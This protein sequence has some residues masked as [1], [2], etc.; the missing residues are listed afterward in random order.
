MEK[1]SAYIEKIGK[2]NI[3]I[4]VLTLVTLFVLY[5]SLY[6]NSTEDSQKVRSIK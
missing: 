6:T 3:A 4:G 2:Q 1:F 5:R